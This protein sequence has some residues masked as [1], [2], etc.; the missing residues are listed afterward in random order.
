MI[1][2]FDLY[3]KSKQKIYFQTILLLYLSFMKIYFLFHHSLRTTDLYITHQHID[4]NFE[5]R[6]SIYNKILSLFSS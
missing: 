6:K 5:Q 1:M 3:Y 2:L 4:V